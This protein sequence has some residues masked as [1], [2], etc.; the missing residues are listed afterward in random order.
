MHVH[1]RSKGK[2][3]Q[4]I[5]QWSSLNYFLTSVLPYKQS[6]DLKNLQNKSCH[7]VMGSIYVLTEVRY[8]SC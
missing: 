3:V 7:V 2:A 8:A 1:K 6:F 5:P 4:F